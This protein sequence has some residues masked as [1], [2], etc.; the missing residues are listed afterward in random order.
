MGEVKK[1]AFE[2]GFEQ[3]KSMMLQYMYCRI[4]QELDSAK[5]AKE[6]TGY[7]NMERLIESLAKLLFSIY[8]QYK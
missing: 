4:R 3:G 6:L 7:D 1:S 8:H 5:H 2:R